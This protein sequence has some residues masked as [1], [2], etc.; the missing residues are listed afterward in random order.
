MRAD[1]EGNI[2]C[3]VGW[4]DPEED[5]VRCYSPAGELLG[6]PIKED[7]RRQIGCAVQVGEAQ[8]IKQDTEETSHMGRR[9]REA[10]YTISVAFSGALL[11]A[12][13]AS[14][15]TPTTTPAPGV[16]RWRG[17]RRQNTYNP[18]ACRRRRPASGP[19]RCS[20]TFTTSRRASFSR[21]GRST[22]QAISGSLPSAAGGCLLF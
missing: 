22:R 7:G 8:M 2:W 5:G 13:A 6:K 19:F 12:G 4:G 21:V 18:G 1:V 20:L 14:A 15:Q 3:S 9:V 11:L 10:I 16:A 17:L